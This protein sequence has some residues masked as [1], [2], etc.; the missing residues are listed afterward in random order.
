MNTGHRR[1]KE[2]EAPVEVVHL[3]INKS[4]SLRAASGSTH[5]EYRCAASEVE[6][7]ERQDSS[8]KKRLSLL[9]ELELLD[10]FG[11]RAPGCVEMSRGQC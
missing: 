9:C 1:G 4:G 7:R 10:T 2:R 11:R 8:C 6:I 5:S 3:L